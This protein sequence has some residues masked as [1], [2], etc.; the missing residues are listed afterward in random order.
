M[1]N[2]VKAAFLSVGLSIAAFAEQVPTPTMSGD[3]PSIDYAGV[4]TCRINSSTGTTALLCTSNPV[5]VYG[6]STSSIAA[7]AYLRLFST[8]SIALSGAMPV[9]VQF[10]DNSQADEDVTATQEYNWVRPVVFRKGLVLKASVAPDDATGTN[11]IEWNV[12]YREVK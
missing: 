11:H 12:Y 5:I 2:F 1:R 4:S 7:T 8:N 9:K 10:N 3:N 6:V